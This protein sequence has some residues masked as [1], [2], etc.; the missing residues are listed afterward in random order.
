MYILM[1]LFMFNMFILMILI[2]LNWLISM[3]K[4]NLREKMTSFEC[5]FNKFNSSRLP[6]SIHFYLIA[7][8]FLI[9][10]IEIILLFPML[11]SL[12]NLNYKFWM[13][14]MLMFMLI[15]YLGLEF[16]KNQGVLK[17]FT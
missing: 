1:L 17:W 13:Y 4:Y 11:N 12:M 2:M 3:N 5:G 7:L 15:L 6:F 9:F 16:E 10:D 8:L 14:S